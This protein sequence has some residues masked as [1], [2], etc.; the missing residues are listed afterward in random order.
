MVTDQGE[1]REAAR[2]EFKSGHGL[3]G[4]RERVELY[5]GTMTAGRTANGFTV[6][7]LLPINTEPGTLPG[8]AA[9]ATADR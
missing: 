8:S 1:L 3:L 6:K 7:A 2:T 5:G 9:V 4:M